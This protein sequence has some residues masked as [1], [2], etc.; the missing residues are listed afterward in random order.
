MIRI[1][2]HVSLI[3]PNTGKCGAEELSLGIAFGLFASC[4]F[5]LI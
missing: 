5:V 1:M 4:V 3:L 2:I